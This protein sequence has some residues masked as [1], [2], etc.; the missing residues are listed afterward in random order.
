MNP[1]YDTDPADPADAA[2]P[3]DLLDSDASL[4]DYAPR[5]RPVPCEF[6]TGRAGTGKS[7]QVMKQAAE[8]PSWA[9]LSSTTGVS[10][11]NLGCTT[12]NSLLGYFDEASLQDIYLSGLLTR[13]L[14]SFADAGIRNLLIEEC[15]MLTAPALDLLYR[16]AED[17]ARLPAVKEPLGII[18][19]GDFAQLPPVKGRWCFE[20]QCWPKFAAATN[21]LTTVW[22]Q[23]DPKFLDAL[24]AVRRGD[25]AEAAARLT[26]AG[27]EWHTSL[28]T[29]FDGTTILPKNEMVNRYNAMALDRVRGASIVVASRRWG[30]QRSEW[31]QNK[32]TGEWGVPQQAEFKVG[33][34]VM[35]LANKFDD[36]RQLVYANGDCGHIEDY[37]G[38][39]GVF[40]V[41]LVRNGEV[42]AVE[43]LARNVAQKDRPDNWPP[44]PRGKEPVYPATWIGRPHKSRD[45]YVLGQVEFYPI[46]LAYASSV[47]KSQSLSL[48]RVQLDYRDRFF[49]SPAMLYVAVSRARSLAGLR[50]VG[51]REVFQMRC[52]A[53]PKVREFL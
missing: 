29:E 17:V 19:V 8:D 35:L 45:G 52:Q 24:D 51:Q 15:S 1:I 38:G 36:S 27:V 18:L 13:K 30:K 44:H 34:Y 43:R 48:D 50:L 40:K 21:R 10:S 12:L 49:G 9:V 28:A 7:F 16:A 46:R 33:A 11:I 26:A 20:A 3:S 5:E 47:H 4:G 37:D 2:D 41:R 31:G 23:S 53:D 25:G 14:R 39:A 22:R 6:R 42:V 32:R